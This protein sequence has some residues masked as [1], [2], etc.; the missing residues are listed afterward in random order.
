M[1]KNINLRVVSLSTTPP[2]EVFETYVKNRPWVEYGEDN[3]YFK[4]VIDRYLNSTT[5][6][7]CINGISDM[8][9]GCGLSAKNAAIKPNDYVSMLSIFKKKDIR[10]IVFDYKLQGMAA[11]QIIWSKDHKKIIEAAHIPVERLRP[12]L[13]N[14]NGDVEA[15]YYAQDWTNIYGK[16]KPKRIPAFGMSNQGLEIYFIK[17]YT[18]NMFY[19]SPPDY[20]A[21]LIYARYEE[22]IADFH[23]NNV[24]NGFASK[25]LINF[26]NGQ[27]STE[28]EKS[29]ITNK[30]NKKFSGVK[31]SPILLSFNDSKEAETTIENLPITDAAD[32]FQ[33]GSKESMEKIMI[34]HRVTSPMLF[35]LS[36]QN[37]FASN[38]DELKNASIYMENKV[39]SNFREELIDVFK[40]LLAINGISLDLF[41]K[42]TQP[43]KS[44]DADQIDAENNDTATS[45]STANLI[46]E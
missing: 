41:F 44:E 46:T 15:Y 27:A 32:Q 36:T 42:T 14:E 2:I 35:G 25:T 16:R 30:I 38:A 37:G 39:I 1:E 34:G 6:A 18:P 17:G 40:E 8:I 4:Y 11:I 24:E 7:A 21:A 3:A 31:G 22:N 20:S 29:D 26:N 12:E 33:F 23:I 19:F 28:E 5:N 13:V 9:Y 10:R 45:S 43:W